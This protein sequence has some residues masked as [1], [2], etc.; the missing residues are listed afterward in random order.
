MTNNSTKPI[1]GIIILLDLK[2]EACDFYTIVAANGIA[3]CLFELPQR[4]GYYNINREVQIKRLVN[5][6]T[7]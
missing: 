1:C 2:E 3:T 7:H 4:V 6:S 5:V